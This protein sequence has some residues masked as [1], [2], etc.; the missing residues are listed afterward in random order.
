MHMPSVGATTAK[1]EAEAPLLVAGAATCVLPRYIG[2][3]V[4]NTDCFG[5]LLP[6]FEELYTA[7]I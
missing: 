2:L 1:C 3:R 5:R 6:R 4:V 7:V